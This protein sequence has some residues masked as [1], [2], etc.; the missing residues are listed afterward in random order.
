MSRLSDPHFDDIYSMSKDIKENRQDES[1]TW[2][3][4]WSSLEADLD[5]MLDNFRVI[6]NFTITIK[7]NIESFDSRTGTKANGYRSIIR[8]VATLVRHCVD[9]L[10]TVKHQQS[11]L[12]YVTS[13]V[14]EDIGTWLE[15]TGRM[16][17]ILELVVHVKSANPERLYPERPDSKSEEVLVLSNKA[18][19]IDL[20]PFYGSALAFHLRGDSRRMMHPLA[21]SMASYSGAVHKLHDHPSQSSSQIIKTKIM[22]LTAESEIDSGIG[23]SHKH[24]GVQITVKRNMSFMNSPIQTCMAEVYLVSSNDSGNPATAGHTSTTPSRWQGRLWTTQGTCRW[25]S[26]RASTTCRRASGSPP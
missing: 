20:A 1:I 8:V 22:Y 19:S 13:E 9:V 11:T 17:E 2:A 16:I 4:S 15:V 23:S 18:L 7:T 21:I 6:Q 25:T 12:G 14:Q 3:N 26:C 10:E 24:H 5:K